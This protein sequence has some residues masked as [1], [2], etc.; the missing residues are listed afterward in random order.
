MAEGLNVTQQLVVSNLPQAMSV[1]KMSLDPVEGDFASVSVPAS[2]GNSIENAFQ[3]QLNLNEYY[4]SIPAAKS[5]FSSRSKILGAPSS[6]VV[7]MP[8]KKV[9]TEKSPD[10]ELVGKSTFGDTEQMFNT[11][12][13]LVVVFAALVFSKLCTMK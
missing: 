5:E 8:V 11:R 6:K 13:L 4:K 10:T 3:K 2:S 7:S 9:N 1:G 12:T